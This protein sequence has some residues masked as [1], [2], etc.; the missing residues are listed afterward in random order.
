MKILRPVVGN[1]D[2]LV[3]LGRM[4]HAES[5]Y[6]SLPY[7]PEYVRRYIASA[8]TDLTYCPLIAEADGEIVGFFCGQISQTFFGPALIA[9]DH[10]LFV[11]Q[12]HRG[13]RAAL[14]LLAEF[15]AWAKKNGA[16]QI[17]MGITTGV[18]EWRTA[19]F[20]DRCG[21]QIT[22]RVMKKELTDVR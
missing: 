21:F 5:V 10:V 1:L 19:Q 20:Y 2:R 11:L 6:A 15:Q 12:A 14:G 17:F 16:V 9:S 13:T 22:G 18:D 7:E 8:I 4:M 3:E